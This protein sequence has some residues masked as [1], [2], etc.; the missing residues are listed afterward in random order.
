[1]R[2]SGPIVAC[3][4][5]VVLGFVLVPDPST[6]PITLFVHGPG[7]PQDIVL[8]DSGE[9]VIDLGGDRRRVIIGDQGQ[10]YFPAIPANFR[11]QEVLVW[12]SSDKF[13]SAEANQKYKLDRQAVYLAVRRKAGRL[14]G[15]VESEYPPCLAGVRAKV[16]GLAVPI[17][18]NSGRF[19]IS[20]PGDHLQDDLVLDIVGAGCTPQHVN[21]VPNSNEIRIKLRRSP[22]D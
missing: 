9:V 11:G 19:D 2:L 13:E 8:Q 4:L 3:F 5:V 15:L 7:G 18:P 12:V 22:P 1:M 17:D 16:A 14:Y 10:A 6:F 20:I 21:V